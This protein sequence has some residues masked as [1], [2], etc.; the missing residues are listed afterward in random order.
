LQ[1]VPSNRLAF[2][3]ILSPDVPNELA[4]SNWMK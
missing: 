4:C 2:M 3:P 1:Q